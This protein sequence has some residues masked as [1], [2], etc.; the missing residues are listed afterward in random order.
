MRHLT[1]ILFPVLILELS[2]CEPSAAK[3]APAEAVRVVDSAIS[4]EEALRRFRDGLP[5]VTSFDGGMESKKDLL[6]AY[7]RGLETRDTVALARY[8]LSRAEFAWLYY[9]WS[10]QG[11]P[12]YDVEPGLMWFLLSTH[13][14]RGLR[15]ALGLYGGQKLQLLDYDCGTKG[16]QEDVNTLWGPCALRWRDERGNIESRR[17]V[18]QIIERDGRFKI[19]SYSNKL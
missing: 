19:L 14:D 9:P 15:R 6:A 1:L 12:P 18:S 5:R 4:R 13:S 16:T 11:L 10:S 8:G 2:G 3:N 17:L 7:L